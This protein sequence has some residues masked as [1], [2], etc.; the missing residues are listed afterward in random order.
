MLAFAA[1]S[2]VG[3]RAFHSTAR[4]LCPLCAFVSRRTPTPPS[5]ARPS[6]RLSITSQ[7]DNSL[8][9]GVSDRVRAELAADG[10]NLDDLLNAGKVVNLTRKL[11]ALSLE[12][13]RG[14]LTDAGRG[15]VESERERLERQL[16]SEKRAVMGVFMK[17]VFVVQSVVFGLLGGVLAFDAVPGETLPVVAKALGF[18]MVWLFSVPALRARKGIRRF[19]K[20]ALNVAF[21]AMPF[22]NVG[23]AG[24]TRECGVIWSV[25]VALLGAL[26]MFY[27]VQ[28]VVRSEEEE[29]VAETA[30]IRG[31]LRYLDWGSWR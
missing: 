1:S 15:E 12:L 5:R 25:D 7:S 2:P 27:G 29:P 28:S 14:G 9:D 30:K 31:V 24:V 23:M 22:V 8:D 11:D 4:P 20:S 17:R 16:A 6:R 10:V 21:L 26:Y 13:E 3:T 18:W 19:E